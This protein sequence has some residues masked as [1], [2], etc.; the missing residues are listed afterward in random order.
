M[1]VLF[2]SRV[3]LDLWRKS[4]QW[5]PVPYS[6]FILIWKCLVWAGIFFAIMIA[7]ARQSCS[8]RPKTLI[9]CKM[10]IFFNS[11][12]FR[13][14]AAAFAFVLRVVHLG[15][16][17]W[18]YLSA[19]TAVIFHHIWTILTVCFPAQ[20]H[21]METLITRMTHTHPYAHVLNRSR[22]SNQ[23]NKQ[24][25]T[26]VFLF[27]FRSS[28]HFIFVGCEAAVW[29]AVVDPIPCCLWFWLVYGLQIIMPISCVCSLVRFHFFK[30]KYYNIHESNLY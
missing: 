22:I 16:G 3:T 1:A 18:A 8:H 6:E 15:I 20:S 12:S 4:I 9:Y 13:M 25:V 7:I 26:T 30:F 21:P 10:N 5:T 29:V 17:L 24:F 2:R 11:I 19:F 14:D 28:V 23:N 27:T